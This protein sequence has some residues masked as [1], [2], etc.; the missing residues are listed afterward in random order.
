V[1]VDLDLGGQPLRVKSA[2]RTRFAEGGTVLAR[3]DP[4]KLHV[5]DSVSGRRIDL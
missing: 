5:F 2:G 4:A 1:I 3:M